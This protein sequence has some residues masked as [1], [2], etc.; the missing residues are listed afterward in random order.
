MRECEVH[1]TTNTRQRAV[2]PELPPEE[3]IFQ[4]LW[5]PKGKTKHMHAVPRAGAEAG[6]FN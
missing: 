2:T 3:T 4:H 5:P 6:Y 1:P